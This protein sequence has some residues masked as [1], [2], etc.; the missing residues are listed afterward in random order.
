MKTLTCIVLVVVSLVGTVLAGEP[1]K[2]DALIL[3]RVEANLRLIY[4]ADSVRYFMGLERLGE[5][6]AVPDSL[7]SQRIIREMVGSRL[8]IADDLSWV[9]LVTTKRDTVVGS[10]LFSITVRILYDYSEPKD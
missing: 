9:A 2:D 1:P 8:K 10:P 4:P 3:K 5:T 7:L 6:I